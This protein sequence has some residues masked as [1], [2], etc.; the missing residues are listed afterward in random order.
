MCV[1]NLR[2]REMAV[3]TPQKAIMDPAQA[4][5]SPLEKKVPVP[6]RAGNTAAD[7]DAQLRRPSLVGLITLC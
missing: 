6:K 2:F 7:M 4:P 3:G 1:A 5:M